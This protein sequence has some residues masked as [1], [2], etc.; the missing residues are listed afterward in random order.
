MQVGPTPSRM[1]YLL[2]ENYHKAV[3]MTRFAA[4]VD[5]KES[6]QGGQMFRTPGP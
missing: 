3:P 1:Q 5:T 4:T 2:W 6:V